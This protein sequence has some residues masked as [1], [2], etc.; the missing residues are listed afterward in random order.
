MLS[1]TGPKAGGP[2]YLFGFS[3]LQMNQDNK[4]THEKDT[5]TNF[6]KITATTNLVHNE[7]EILSSFQT[8]RDYSIDE[9]LNTSLRY[10]TSYTQIKRIKSLIELPIELS[11]PTGEA[12]SLSY[13]PRGIIIFIPSNEMK[14]KIIIKTVSY[15][16]LRAH[17]TQ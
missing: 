14:E 5:N 6:E 17:E 7:I 9:R 3:K 1:G 11:S 12:N 15:T 13:E 8:W 10:K 4:I 16:H 2:N